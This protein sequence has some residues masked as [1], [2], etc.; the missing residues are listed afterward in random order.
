M[1]CGEDDSSDDDDGTEYEEEEEENIH[2]DDVTA[3]APMEN[4]EM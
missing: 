2:A 4:M 1:Q 3:S